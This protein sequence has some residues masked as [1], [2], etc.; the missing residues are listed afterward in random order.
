LETAIPKKGC[1]KEGC[2]NQWKIG[3]VPKVLPRAMAET[4][5]KNSNRYEMRKEFEPDSEPDAG[6]SHGEIREGF[7]G[8]RSI[9]PRGLPA[10]YMKTREED[11]D[12][13]HSRKLS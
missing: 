7:T 6:K 2:K 13:W 11:R 5:S 9:P 8:P 1:N 3:E 4:E 10:R 12:T